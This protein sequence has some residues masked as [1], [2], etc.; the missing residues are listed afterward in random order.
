MPATTRVLRQHVDV[1]GM[2]V[3]CLLRPW[4][5]GSVLQCNTMLSP[6]LCRA[7]HGILKQLLCFGRV[8]W[9]GVSVGV[10]SE[11]L[12]AVVLSL[13]LWVRAELLIGL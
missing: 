6:T 8:F 10:D 7:L 3:V 11:A 4:W 2:H 5:R 9:K 13:V 12:L 1:P